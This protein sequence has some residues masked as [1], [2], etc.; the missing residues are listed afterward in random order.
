MIN[1]I[2]YKVRP[3]LAFKSSKKIMGCKC[4]FKTVTVGCW[5]IQGLYE[6]VN[7]IKT[8]KLDNLLFLNTL[9]KFDVLCIQET[10]V[11]HEE[12]LPSLKDF[13]SIPHCREKSGNNRYFGG[14][15]VLVRKSIEKG[16]KLG[17]N[18]DA[19][20]FEVTL[21][22]KFFHLREDTKILFTYASPLNSSYTKTR[23]TN[24]L[25]KL[26]T[27]LVDGGENYI[28]MGDLNGRTK[29]GDDFVRDGSDKHSPINAPFYTKDTQLARTNPD[30]HPIDQQGRKILQICKSLPVRILNG[31]THGDLPGRWTRYPM[32]PNENPSVIDYSLCSIPIMEDI[33]SF[34]VLPFTGI[35]DHCCISVNIKANVPPSEN[36]PISSNN[37][38]NIYNNEVG[39][40]FDIKNKDLFV[41]N[42]RRSDNIEKL[43]HSINQTENN[44][45]K[46]E[47]CI[48][49]LNEVLLTAARKSFMS[50]KPNKTTPKTRKKQDWFTKECKAKQNSFKKHS[51]NLYRTTFCPT[52]L[53]L[54]LK[55]RSSYKKTCRKAEKAFRNYLRGQLLNS[56]KDEPRK[57][58]NIIRKMNKWGKQ[59]SDPAD[60]ISPDNWNAY[61]KTLL[62]KENGTNAKKERNHQFNTFEPTLDGRI[63]VDELRMALK[64]LKPGKAVG[65]DGVLAEYLRIFG[66]TYE[67][68]LH[69]I[70]NKIF[71]LHTYPSQ[72]NTNFLKPIYKK[73]DTGD[74]DNFRGLAI[75]SA[76]AKL[77]SLILLKRLSTYVNTKKI[78]YPNQIG[79]VKGHST[80]DHIFLLQ[81]IIEKVVK[82]GKQKLYTAFID[83]KKAYDT[84]DRKLLFERMK[85]LD[86][87]GL[88]L[89]NVM[90]MYKHTRYS[91]KLKD[92]YLD[93]LDSNL[94]LKQGCPLS[95]LLFNLYIDDINELFHNQC[96]PIN[97]QGSEINH[98]LY[99]DD[100]VLLSSTP[101]GLQK[102]INNLQEFSKKKEL[103]ISVKKSK[104]LVF[105]PAGRFMKMSFKLD[106]KILEPVQTFCYLGF[107]LRA[108]GTVK[109]AMNNLYDKSSKAMR[110]LLCAISRFNLPVRT[111]IRLFHTYIS[112]ILLYNVE[113]WATF[114]D[115]EIRNAT[116]ETIF[117]DLGNKTDIL[118]RKFLKFLL[119]TT[120]SCQNMMIYGETGEIPLSL[121]GFRLMVNYWHRL[122]SLPDHTLAK[123]AFL[124]NIY[125]RTNWI[126]TIEKLMNWY[127][128]TNTIDCSSKFKN[129]SHNNSRSKFIEAWNNSVNEPNMAKLQFYGKIKN[130][131]ILEKYLDTLNFKERQA[132]TK[133]RCSDHQLEIER[134]RYNGIMRS[135]RTCRLCQNND[136]ESEEHFLMDCTFYDYLKVKHKLIG[137]NNVIDFMNILDPGALGKYLIEAFEIRQNQLEQIG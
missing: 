81:T 39:Y 106:Q 5:N 58:W 72:W 109:N 87:N 92:G 99:A 40:T 126:I 88:F 111:S 90:S 127:N 29:L 27:K 91:I 122:T 98:F 115:K 128:L 119:G 8:C 79:F 137:M 62:N 113:N 84:V 50:K 80:S 37:K 85:E 133:L 9:K 116:N 136:I 117:A 14:F 17:K 22:E 48:E 41:Q 74:P 51:R 77:F 57:F 135:E 49:I 43:T 47:N 15:L 35:S 19:D 105:N 36:N 108:S 11:P 26:E 30:T 21:L 78:L 123:K 114:T 63:S 44:S 66:N 70:V 28:I 76:F 54:F 38:T 71:S 24:I 112:P 110:P 23:D 132:I 59:Q 18:S 107:D 2:H 94:G 32:K 69:K 82:R 4:F 130:E 75:G 56:G 3:Q 12:K 121:K 134:G 61:F 52:N 68:I 55:A 96:D 131:F 93:A 95:P 45:E 83:F 7:G 20:A 60:N 67:G 25:D 73:G 13:R 104:T 100:L 124:E 16:I 6:N 33:K 31:R 120:K 34:T 10:H 103:T 65:P 53:E 89:K 118:H 97:L 125:L 46:I 101:E 86:I 102:C 64:D 129:A 42:L 1:T